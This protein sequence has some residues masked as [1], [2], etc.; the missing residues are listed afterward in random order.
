MTVTKRR[1]V[2]TDRHTQRED[3]VEI[4]ERMPCEDEAEIVVMLDY[5]QNLREKCG[6]DSFSQ[7]LEGTILLTP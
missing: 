1:N 4:Q 7:P 5:P 3:K 2:D 6:A